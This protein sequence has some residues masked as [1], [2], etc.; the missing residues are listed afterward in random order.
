MA[1]LNRTIFTIHSWLGLIAGIFFLVFSLTGSVLVFR[2][3]IDAWQFP[4]LYQVEPQAGQV[5]FDALY[6][7]VLTRYPGYYPYGIR[8]IPQNAVETVEF[9]LQKDNFRE[10]FSV[11]YNPHTGQWL[12][13][14]RNGV[15]DWLLELHYTFLMGKPGET[16]AALFAI[17]LLGSVLTGI[18]VYRK[19]VVHVLLFRVKLKTHNWR[20]LSSDLHR[21]LGVWTLI[22]NTV[23]ALSGVVLLRYALDVKTHFTDQSDSFT[24]APPASIFLDSAVTAAYR[25]LPGLSIHYVSFPRKKGDKL[26]VSGDVPGNMLL[27]EYN[28]SVRFD[29]Q[30]GAIESVAKET[31]LTTAQKAEYILYTLHFG[32]YGGTTIKL[33]VCVF[34]LATAVITLTGFLLWYRRRTKRHGVPRNRLKKSAKS[35]TLARLPVKS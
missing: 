3:E 9:G 33:L 16:L 6:R 35:P 21:V 19:H 27:G 20:V 32:Q 23:F 17:A 5:S 13:E 4:H 7:D 18:I 8:H 1:R 26:E 2:E 25:Q 30:T 28:N 14:K 11:Y 24:Q 22:F 15:Y 29:P 34:G 12:G 31:E 10:R